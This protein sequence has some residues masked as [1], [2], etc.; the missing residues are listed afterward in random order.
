MSLSQKFSGNGVY[1]T[2]CQRI[3]EH[4]G[5]L[6]FSVH[7]HLVWTNLQ[8]LFLSQQKCV[9]WDISVMAC[10]HC[11]GTGDNGFL[12]Y[13]MY[14][15]HYTRTGTGYHCFLL[16]PSRS[17][18]VC[19]SH[20]CWRGWHLHWYPR[21]HIF[22]ATEIAIAPREQ[23]YNHRGDRQDTTELTRGGWSALN[24]ESMTENVKNRFSETFSGVNDLVSQYWV[25]WGRSF[26][27]FLWK[28]ISHNSWYIFGF[29]CVFWKFNFHNF[30]L[31]TR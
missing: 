17:R 4:I 27:E 24:G 16:C 5:N 18:A 8:G 19:L 14:C 13:T 3:I 2:R 7:C 6:S 29:L 10:S 22:I 25:F 28:L 31:G 11:T 12:Y 21:E 15:A 30:E 9:L 23:S 26:L 20:K 1:Q